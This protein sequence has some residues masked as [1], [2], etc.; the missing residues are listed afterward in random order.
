MGAAMMRRIASF[1]AA[2]ALGAAAADDV[3]TVYF[4]VDSHA[5]KAEYDVML[6]AQARK[7]ATH[8]RAH[9]SIDGHCDEANTR[10]YNLALAQRRADAVRSELRKLGAPDG[11]ME[12]RG[13]EAEAPRGT[14][15][16]RRVDLR[17]RD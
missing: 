15:A 7:L 8:P 11:R 12:S 5:V 16:N 9:L 4:D 10:A 2:A 14:A 1:A 3:Q 6:A 13:L 17:F